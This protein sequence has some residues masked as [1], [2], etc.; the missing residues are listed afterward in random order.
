[1]PRKNRDGTGQIL[2][3][4]S[5]QGHT[6]TGT[7]Y[8]ADIV[9]NITIT[10]VYEIPELYSPLGYV[11]IN[12]DTTFNLQDVNCSIAADVDPEYGW[13]Q[14]TATTTYGNFSFNGNASAISIVIT[15]HS[16]SINDT[17]QLLSTYFQNVLPHILFDFD[18]LYT[19]SCCQVPLHTIHT[20]SHIS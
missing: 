16:I 10:Q 17:A 18:F 14:L 4:L 11:T 19:D 15:A 2:I 3:S 12:E 5:D 7:H 20:N 1:M 13:L 6:G 8:F 9:I